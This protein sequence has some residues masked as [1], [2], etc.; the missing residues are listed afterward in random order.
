MRVLILGGT[1]FL[2]RWLVS[3]LLQR[4]HEITLFNRGLTNPQL[5]PQVIQIHGDRTTELTAL[6]NGHWDAVVDTSGYAP[7][8]V[9]RSANMLSQAVERYVFISTLSVYADFSLTGVDEESALAILAAGQTS[10]EVNGETY[11]PLKARCEQAVQQALPG[12]VLVVRPGLIV[13][14]Y[15]PSDRFTYWPHRVAQG[16]EVLAP[17]QRDRL[18]Q[19]IDVRDLVAWIAQMLENGQIG[20]YNATGPSTPLTMQTLLDTCK[21]VSGSDATFTWVSEDF[22]RRENVGE[23]LELPLWLAETDPANRG[24]FGVDISKA[25]A[26]GLRF[27]PLA[28]TVR[29]TLEW[30]KTTEA[31]REWRAGLTPERE[32]DLLMR[33]HEQ[34]GD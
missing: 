32:T 28:D 18:I 16:G 4:G 12:R 9:R 13:G 33:W 11:G 5:F 3:E 2:G 31:D 26:M 30:D 17:G 25:T 15:D 27:R 8:V 21:S 14:P 34:H 24:F 10:E 19:F 29:A 20:V 1:K 23:W 7:S 6:A 22:L